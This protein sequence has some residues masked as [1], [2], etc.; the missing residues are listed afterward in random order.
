MCLNLYSTVT[1]RHHNYRIKSTIPSRHET[2][3]PRETSAMH[4]E[5]H[6][7]TL[8][9]PA[10]PSFLFYAAG[11]VLFILSLSPNILFLLQYQNTSRP[12]VYALGDVCGKALLTP[13]TAIVEF[14][15]PICR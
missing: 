13:G 3:N 9:F 8:N 11:L 5:R 2:S 4:E 1:S 14:Q 10:K 6:I 15:V 7:L 12:N